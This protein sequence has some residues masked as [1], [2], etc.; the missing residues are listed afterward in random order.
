MAIGPSIDGKRVFNVASTMLCGHT[1]VHF[2]VKM[3]PF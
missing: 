2:E 3:R 1:V